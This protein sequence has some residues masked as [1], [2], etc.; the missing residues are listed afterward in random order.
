MK[1]ICERKC[2]VRNNFGQAI[3]YSVGEVA[4]FDECPAYFRPL[5][6]EDVA[7][8]DFA[9]AGREELMEREDY[10]LSDLKAYIESAYGV[11]AGNRGKEKTVDLLLD[12][13]VR[14]VGDV[15]HPQLTAEDLS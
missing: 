10:A 13:R 8:L 15:E 11:K 14:A 5:E 1:C 4:E 6:G 2:Q 12:C 3:L 7:P 9:T